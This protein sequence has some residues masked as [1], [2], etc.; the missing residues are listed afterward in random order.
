MLS[1][2]SGVELS[3]NYFLYPLTVLAVFGFSI[4]IGIVAGL[5]PAF[6]L[7]SFDP[8]TVLKG[9]FIS[10]RSGI[11][12]RYGL[13]IFQFAIC[14]ILIICTIVV[15][16]QMQYM[17]GDKL[18]F[19]KDHIISV[20]RVWQ[21]NNRSGDRVTDS[22]KSFV[23]DISK[24]SGVE[25][26]T[27]CDRLPGNDESGGGATWLAVDNNASRTDRMMQVDD[28]YLKL[29]DLQLK[30][31]R[32][33][34]KEFATDSLSLILNEKA[35]EDFG[36]KNPIGAKLISKE[37]YLNSTDGKEQNVFTVVGVIRDFHYQSLHKKIAPLIFVNSNKF[38][39]GTV[40]V[41]IGG[42]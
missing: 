33:F 39:W 18:G 10:N 6:V 1:R 13:V 34:S 20:E 28:K 25:D 38:G 42:H 19:I 30:E 41:K 36:L 11:A 32:F 2:I 35:V 4:F 14:V 16:M 23:D 27:E 29:L 37:Q 31:G 17:L 40:G 21:L 3:F 8:I 12:L 26:I 7:S 9:K 15:N 5:Y 22:R 24:I